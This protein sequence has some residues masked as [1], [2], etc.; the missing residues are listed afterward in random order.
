MNEPKSDIYTI[1]SGISGAT[2]YQMRPGVM[3][4]IPCYIYQIT[5]NTPTYSLEG[6][7]EYQDISV[8]IDIYANNSKESGSL[9][10]TLV[11]TMIDSGYRM[12]YASDIPD[13][14]LSHI[15]TE[16]NLVGY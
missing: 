10:T 1:L 5:G 4:D 11:E 7:I 14:N 6:E 16:F 9:L 12:I 3:K 15:A 8:S 13:D 2:T